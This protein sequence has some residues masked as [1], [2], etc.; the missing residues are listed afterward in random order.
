MFGGIDIKNIDGVYGYLEEGPDAP[1]YGGR[2]LIDAKPELWMEDVQ[3]LY[4]NGI[5]IKIPLSAYP[6]FTE[7]EYEATKPLLEL[8]HEEINTIIVA[9]D[10]LADRIRKDFPKY[11]IELS[12]VRNI[13]TL[14]KLESVIDKYDIVCLPIESNDN[15]EFLKNIDQKNKVRLFI[16]AECSY[17]CPNKICYKSVSE[18][19]KGDVKTTTCSAYGLKV[20]RKFYRD[21]ID[22]TKFY[23]PVVEYEQMGFSKFKVLNP[24]D[25]IG[26][27]RFMY[28][29]YYEKGDNYA[30][31]RT[32]T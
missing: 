25:T 1:L 18:A 22:W 28:S 17:N 11:K 7:Q 13:N 23:F 14:D 26:N 15:I 4:S 3:F 10:S 16:N 6:S 27:V 32:D 19:N 30:N 5:G 9:I 12:A 31:R 20:P 8:Y 24:R 2:V 29:N 21:E